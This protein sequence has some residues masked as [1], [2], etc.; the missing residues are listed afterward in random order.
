M[1]SLCTTLLE[2]TP[3]PVDKAIFIRG[4]GGGMGVGWA[5]KAGVSIYSL[6]NTHL[7]FS[8]I[9]M[10]LVTV[11]EDGKKVFSKLCF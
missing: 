9:K 5:E 4:G 2:I 7:S 3:I 8:L 6:Q 1:Q 10:Y 11:E